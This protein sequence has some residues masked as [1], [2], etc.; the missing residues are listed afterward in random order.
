M[1][2]AE[3]ALIRAAAVSDSAG[4][5]APPQDKLALAGLWF[6]AAEGREPA[7]REAL[8][9][10]AA[11]WYDRVPELAVAGLSRVE[12]LA[13]REQIHAELAGAQETAQPGASS[14]GSEERFTL[15][16]EKGVQALR[17]NRYSDADN[18][19]SQCL[20]IRPNDAAV[21]NNYA[22]TGVRLGHTQRAVRQWQR[23]VDMGLE[24]DVLLHNLKRMKSC[25]QRKT[26]P[27]DTRSERD[28]DDL[29]A[30]ASA[31]GNFGSHTS[32]R[33]WLYFTSQNTVGGFY[34]EDKACMLCDGTGD[35]DC[36]VR[37]CSRGTVKVMSQSVV[38]R[39]SVTGQ[40]IVTS[41][42]VPVPCT[43]CS[44]RGTMS[45]PGCTSGRDPTVAP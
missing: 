21:I 23:I 41:T 19:F 11:Y 22:A 13:R 45:C 30:A 3:D 15:L 34:H 5:V 39:N 29:I 42:P 32:S 12:L 38:G 31:G 17:E 2:K 25:V 44:G 14:A 33:G 9:R 10:R 43:A 6:K 37:G 1:A 18:F 8:L 40:A 28:L 7:L 4:A 26:V 24:A 16:F 27:L 20:G 36:S 35:T